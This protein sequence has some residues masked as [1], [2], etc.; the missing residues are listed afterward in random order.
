[1]N[2]T[3]GRVALGSM[4]LPS[5]RPGACGGFTGNWSAERGLEGPQ[6]ALGVSGAV[7]AHS[8]ALVDGSLDDV[9]AGGA[10]AGVVGI[11]VVHGDHCHP[12][13]GAEGA[14]RLVALGRGVKPDHLVPSSH[15]GMIGPA[16]TVTV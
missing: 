11:G 8:I 5:V 16:V 1:M 3:R 9:G 2:W 13:G 7:L 10:A 14:R 4:A 6:L 12:G 15:F